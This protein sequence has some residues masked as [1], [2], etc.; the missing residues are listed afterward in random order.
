M[1]VAPSRLNCC[2]SSP[3]DLHN[4][5][6]S[7]INFGLG[8]DQGSKLWRSVKQFR[9]RRCYV[10]EP[11]SKAAHPVAVSYEMWWRCTSAGVVPQSSYAAP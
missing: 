10:D 5:T 11:A 3:R 6:P 2:L 9:N 4:H 1:A 8:L 7:C